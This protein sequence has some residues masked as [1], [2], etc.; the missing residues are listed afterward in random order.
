M[1]SKLLISG[2]MT[3]WA[4]FAAGTGLSALKATDRCRWKRILRFFYMAAGLW[5]LFLPYPEASLPFYAGTGVL[6]LAFVLLAGVGHKLPGNGLTALTAVFLAAKLVRQLLE[7]VMT[8][9]IAPLLQNKAW[10]LFSVCMA[11]DTMLFCALCA[12][13]AAATL[14]FLRLFPLL[15]KKRFPAAALLLSALCL[16]AAGAA[17]G[18]LSFSPLSHAVW[19]LAGA[20]AVFFPGT[21]WSVLFGGL[22]AGIVGSFGE[23]FIGMPCKYAALYIAFLI[24]IGRKG[25]TGEGQE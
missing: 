11:T 9:H 24:A 18:T 2:T 17:G 5:F 25:K 4:Y 19:S 16:G 3:G 7:S 23:Y 6:L 13:L 14:I 15:R 1:I 10:E 22:L 20:M 8:E 12:V 21:G